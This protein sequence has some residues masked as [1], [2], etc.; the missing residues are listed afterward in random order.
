ME[1]FNPYAYLKESRKQITGL[2]EQSFVDHGALKEISRV[3]LTV[4]AKLFS[5]I[6]YDGM[7]VPNCCT[8]INE[9]WNGSGWV[10]FEVLW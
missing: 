9:R 8:S 3:Q 10:D 5:H 6:N 7:A 4:L 2:V 1:I